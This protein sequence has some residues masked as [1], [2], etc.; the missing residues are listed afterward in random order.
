M[1]KESPLYGELVGCL[2][3]RQGERPIREGVPVGFQQGPPVG[4]D[5]VIGPM[6]QGDFLAE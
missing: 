1:V 2:V 3:Y 5:W 4:G 6:R